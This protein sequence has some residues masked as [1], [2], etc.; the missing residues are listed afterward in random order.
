MAAQGSPPRY[1]QWPSP[2]KYP[3]RPSP[4]KYPQRPSPTINVQAMPPQPV[5]VGVTSQG[6]FRPQ[7]NAV[8]RFV[9]ASR[10]RPVYTD[11]RAPLSPGKIF[12]QAPGV[13]FQAGSAR[14]PWQ[15]P[16][17]DLRPH[18]DRPVLRFHTPTK[19]PEPRVDPIARVRTGERSPD[20]KAAPKEARTQNLD[21]KGQPDGAP[22]A[23][24]S[25][26]PATSMAPFEAP[27]V[28]TEAPQET[29]QET[30]R[31]TTQETTEE[32][33]Q[34][35]TEETPQ[36]VPQ[37]V[38]SALE[39]ASEM[40]ESPTVHRAGLSLP[41]EAVQRQGTL[42]D[43]PPH[44]SGVSVK[45][46][47]FKKESACCSGLASCMEGISGLFSFRSFTDERDKFEQIV[48]FLGSVPLFKKQ[49]PPSEWPKVAQLLEKNTWKPD[50][51]LV[52][53]G[54]L[55]TTF[56]MIYSGQ[57]VLMVRDDQGE[58]HEGALLSAGD[59]IGGRAIVTE[60]RHMATV[61]A[62]GPDDLVTLSMS[63]QV[64][65]ESGLKSCL[66]FPKRPAIE[67]GGSASA[68]TLAP[69]TPLSP[70]KNAS[71][72]GK[73]TEKQQEFIIRAMKHNPN[74]RAFVDETELGEDAMKDVVSHSEER[75][76]PAGKAAA[77]FGDLGHEFFVIEK[78]SI[79]VVITSGS[80][81][82]K[83]AAAAAATFSLADRIRRK[84]D[85][86]MKLH[87]P[88]VD[89]R[90]KKINR[91]C[92]VLTKDPRLEDEMEKKAK[93]FR[94]S[95]SFGDRIGNF[96]A[97]SLRGDRGLGR[98]ASLD[99]PEPREKVISA[100]HAGDSFGE[101]SLMYNIRREATF[102]AAEDTQLL[103]INRKVFKEITGR[104]NGRRKFKEYCDL[105]DEVDSLTPLLRSQRMELAAYAQ[106]LVDF[107]PGRRVLFQGKVRQKPLWYVIHSG[108]AILSQ[109]DQHTCRK[110][111]ELSR[112]S[113]FGE[114]SLMKAK[115]TGQCISEVSVD[116][117]PGGLKCLT[118]D[119]D[120]ICDIFSSLAGSDASLLPS[121]E[122]DASQWEQQK[123]S[124]CR[125]LQKA[126][127]KSDLNSLHELC[128]LGQGAFG[129][130]FLVK[131]DEAR[132]RYALK[133]VSKGHSARMGTCQSLCWER[134]LL[135]MLD[136]N[137]IVRLHRTLKD[138]Q[139][140]YFLLEAALGGD[141][142]GMFN[143]HQEIFLNDEPRGSTSAFYAGCVI[144]ALEHLHERKII[145]RDLKPENIML[146]TRGY[147]KICDMGLA[148]FVVGKTNTQ[149]GTPDYM[150]PEMIDPPH[151][152]DNSADWWSL[153]VLVYEMMCQQLP[154]EDDELEDTGE[155]LLAIR[156]SQEMRL[157]FPATCPAGGR[158][159]I[160]KLLRKLPHR[161]GAQGGAEEVRA[162]Y[163]WQGFDFGSLHQQAM[164]SPVERPW[165]GQAE[166]PAEVKSPWHRGGSCLSPGEEEIFEEYAEDGSNWDREF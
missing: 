96:A 3:Q 117:G 109:E 12:R 60:Q 72:G 68:A 28:P 155:R 95:P 103:V 97:A 138:Q 156:R 134:D 164:K 27:E 152:H 125:S 154:F 157:D 4:T 40:E 7:V 19:S 106:D 112:G 25:G 166:T 34:E 131:D 151:Y 45:V 13:P 104:D 14:L 128:R 58:E 44:S 30:P 86:L 11:F 92:S 116:A 88:V 66:H 6:T 122:C 115:V 51:K 35:T 123:G 133:R 124:T 2:T 57:A 8:A 162:H 139:F 121:V 43:E 137:F 42:P 75:C 148:R 26:I 55:G 59:Y 99:Q 93:G 69:T 111:A 50:T 41:K 113:S 21:P 98:I 31:K 29:L 119:G 160:A 79:E 78:G 149:A 46:S 64:F 36:E 54:D 159:F 67:M 114:R 141:L 53:Q 107:E 129:T 85:F 120:L 165:A 147:G 33:P 90:K 91:S 20:A 5:P 52:T 158:A 63:K 108:S 76:I 83:S 100:L 77:T 10:S 84:Q 118:F 105:V 142:Y 16:A 150:A 87:I 24:T 48:T 89:K 18:T 22:D 101:L 1:P 143:S 153:G 32:T 144:A 130:V 145:Y 110:I 65:E 9:E 102:R 49:L 132:R 17:P 73:I 74:F 80:S 15:A 23:S 163:F 61:I 70:K 39:D 161:L 126:Q 56:F 140:V 62:A 82:Q 81:G 37:A 71:F 136:S 146:D 94:R 127:C 47:T 38:A 135:N